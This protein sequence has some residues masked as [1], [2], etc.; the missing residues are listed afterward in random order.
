MLRV[1]YSPDDAKK[2]LE[3]VIPAMEPGFNINTSQGDFCL[4]G[5]DAKQVMELVQSLAQL[6]VNA[7]WRKKLFAQGNK[8]HFL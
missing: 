8:S 1:S 4:H 2:A 5:E 7:E 6:R 3:T